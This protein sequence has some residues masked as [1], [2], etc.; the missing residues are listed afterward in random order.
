MFALVLLGVSPRAA[1]E[2]TP[3]RRT[4]PVFPAALETP[5]DS[6]PFAP[7]SASL[8]G[9]ARG[10]LDRLAARLAV[11]P[12]LR[13]ELLAFAGG[14][15]QQAQAHR[16]SLERALALRQYLMSH[17]I[18]RVRIIVR[19]LG[20]GTGGGDQDRVDVVPLTP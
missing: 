17:G 4:A 13:I 2:P 3:Q 14:S 15:D 19:A 1:A 7:K 11:D 9:S 12:R 5:I 18:P 6:I 10:P 8:P 16:L 20:N